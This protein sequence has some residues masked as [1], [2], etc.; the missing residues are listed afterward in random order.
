[1]DDELL[2]LQNLMLSDNNTNSNNSSISNLEK[3]KMVEFPVITKTNKVLSSNSNQQTM[4]NK[5]NKNLSKS[6]SNNSNGIY[7]L[8][9]KVLE[10]DNLDILLKEL[11]KDLNWCK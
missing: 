1:M 3:E 2:K 4:D 7:N 5:E 6:N 8:I 11:N 10:D 9:N